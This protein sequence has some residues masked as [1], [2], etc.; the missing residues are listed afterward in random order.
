MLTT[1]CE[2]YDRSKIEYLIMQ[3]ARTSS[4]IFSG[5]KFSNKYLYDDIKVNHYFYHIFGEKILTDFS[6]NNLS[7]ILK[8]AINLPRI[9]VGNVMTK[10][11]EA[12][13]LSTTDKF[14][15][16][17]PLSPLLFS[18]SNAFPKFA[19]LKEFIMTHLNKHLQLSH[20]LLS[21]I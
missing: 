20:K 17:V 19:S 18:T 5:I 4:S 14:D 16:K 11:D 21:A 8:N 9:R 2:V 15:D 3:S 10:I 7:E 6:S 12:F 13:L 1:G